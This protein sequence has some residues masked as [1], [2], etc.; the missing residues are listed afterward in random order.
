VSFASNGGT[1]ARTVTGS[2][3]A[4]LPSQLVV[5]PAGEVDFG[6]LPVGTSSEQDAY[7]V[8]NG[9]GGT[10]TGTVSVASPF[11]VVSGGTFNLAA[12]ASQTVRVRFS[13]AAET[14]YSETLSFASNG[15]NTSRTVRGT[16]GPIVIDNRDNA[17]DRRFGVVSGS[18]LTSTWQTGKWLADYHYTTTGDGSAVAAWYFKVPLD[19]IYEVSAW[20]PDGHS[21]WGSNVP[22]R[23]YHRNGNSVVRADQRSNGGKW[24]VLGSYEFPAGTEWRVEIANDSPSSYVLADAIRLRWVRAVVPVLSVAPA[25]DVA[26]GTVL[27]GAQKELDAYTVTNAGEGTL[28]GTVSVPSPFSVV[29]GATFDLVAGA[30]QVVRVRFSP[31]AEADYSEDVSFTSNGGSATRTVTGSAVAT[32][33]PQLVVEPATDVDFGQVP[34]GSSS[35][36]DAYTV[37]N[38]GGGTLTGTASVA[39]PFTVVSGGTFNLAAGASQVVRV[40][41]SPAAETAYSETLSFATNAGNTNRTVSGSGGPVTLVIDN[42]DNAADKRFGV[43]S[44]TWSTSAWQT[45]RWAADYHYTNAGNGSAVAAWYFKVPLDGVYEVSAW[46][47]DGHSAWGSNVPYRTY[48]RNGNSVVRTDQRSNGGKWNVLGSYEFEAGTEWRVE[49]A[50][51]SPSTYVL[52]DAVRL[53]RVGGLEPTI[54]RNPS[55]LTPSCTAGQN[56]ANST[57]EVWNSGT[58]TDTYTVSLSPAVAWIASV[59]PSGGTLAATHQSHT[60]TYSA[61]ALAPGT[62]E[63]DIVITAPGAANSPQSIHVTLTVS[64]EMIID[65]RDNEADK[66]FGVISGSW[67]TSAWQT[68]RWLADYHYTNTGNGSAVAAWYFK[69]PQ[70]GVYEVSAWWPDGHSAWGS[71]VPY[72][73]YHRNGNSVV[74]TDQRS[75]GGRWNVLGSYEFEAGTEYRVEIT[76]DSPSTYVLADAIRVRRTGALPAAGMTLKLGAANVAEPLGIVATPDRGPA[77]LDVLLE[78]TGVAPGTACA[79]DFGDGTTGTGAAAMHTYY[80][81]GTYTITLAASGKTAT[82]TIVATSYYPNIRP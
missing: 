76:N 74:R 75:N 39:S 44:G 30:S 1:Q 27:V 12:G 36:Q 77:P 51:D 81:P 24:N 18:W 78:A 71:N 8:R 16:G 62:Y 68:N 61:A 67:P 56:A 66:R 53:N 50:N 82:A 48:H 4:S 43:V 7:T 37:R 35:E 54:A 14:A 47:P 49:I 64:V 33:P 10:L 5:E 11:S 32:L 3:V 40:R 2:G 20:W 80:S 13:P 9:G 72:R 29:S 52:A 70:D 28:S 41:F 15:G 34:P 59:A 23:T 65:N 45:N 57:F 38:S 17:A 19:G 22:Y 26:F 6:Q 60:V 21:A 73:T 55:A 69:V 42:L 25:G 58:G 46:W 63:T 31:A 79:W